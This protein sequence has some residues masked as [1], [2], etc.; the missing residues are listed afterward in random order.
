MSDPEVIFVPPLAS[1]SVGAPVANPPAP[2][3]KPLNPANGFSFLYQK[4]SNIIE[5]PYQPAPV[6]LII[7]RYAGVAAVF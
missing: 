4:F 7:T 3:P 2:P 1:N 5:P 6:A